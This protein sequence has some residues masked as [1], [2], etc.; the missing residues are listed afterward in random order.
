MRSVSV[1]YTTAAATASALTYN[2]CALILTF[3]AP[4]PTM[5]FTTR[6]NVV[7]CWIPRC[8]VSSVPTNSKNEEEHRRDLMPFCFTCTTLNHFQL[9]KGKL[10][11]LYIVLSS[12]EFI[13]QHI[14][15]TLLH[16]SFTLLL[17]LETFSVEALHQMLPLQTD[18]KFTVFIIDVVFWT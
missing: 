12:T 11:F 7:I 2:A 17:P 4:T 9:K 13:F 18:S 1:K 5:P 10:F 6:S 15:H 16:S 14:I 8:V 3:L